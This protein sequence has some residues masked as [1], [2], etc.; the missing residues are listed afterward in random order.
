MKH[1]AGAPHDYKVQR[2]WE[3]EALQA[4]KRQ[5]EEGCTLPTVC[6]YTYNPRRP[7]NPNVRFDSAPV[8]C[9]RNAGSNTDHPGKGFC[10]YH[11]WKVTQDT[12]NEPM[13]VAAL[14]AEAARRSEFLGKPKPT[15]PHMALLEEVQ[16]SAGMVEWLRETIAQRA[17]VLEKAKEANPSADDIDVRLGADGVLIQYTLKD[18]AKP[19][20]WMQLYNEERAHLI[21]AC[22][23]AIK[24]G[25]AERRVRIA[26]Q[27]GQLIV[28]M[29]QAFIHDP[30]L[31]LTPDQI[32]RAPQ[33]IRRHLAAIPRES[34]EHP[35]QGIIEAH[36]S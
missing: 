19:S 30:E 10:D 28:A 12:K 22:T 4:R 21:R 8:V 6:G 32:M 7:K 18:G 1:D 34:E 35:A 23:A 24:S 27:Q 5:L 25:V 9:M 17:E 26:E 3:N 31:G 33:L 29:F 16:R 15:D 36:A 13:Q 11:D 20:A 14:R 2:K